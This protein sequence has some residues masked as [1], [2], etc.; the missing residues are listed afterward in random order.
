MT[1]TRFEGRTAIV[2]GAAS[3]IGRATAVRL[4][5]DGA[6]VGC[7]DLADAVD[8]TVELIRGAGGTAT[9]ARIAKRPEWK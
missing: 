8:E 3:G 7:V 6:K 4:A 9:A 2:T 1:A 5:A